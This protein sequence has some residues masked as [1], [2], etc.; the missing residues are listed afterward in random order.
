MIDTAKGM[1]YCRKHMCWFKLTDGC[2]VCNKLKHPDCPQ[3]NS[4]NSQSA[5]ITNNS[6]HPDVKGIAHRNGGENIQVTVSHSC[7]F[8]DF[9]CEE[10]LSNQEK[11]FSCNFCGADRDYKGECPKC[12]SKKRPSKKHSPNLNN[13]KDGEE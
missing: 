6:Q 11:E 12:F 8:M 7:G 5:E 1:K 10:C 9:L 3:P 4:L 13:T 2:G